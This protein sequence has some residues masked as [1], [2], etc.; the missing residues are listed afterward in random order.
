MFSVTDHTAPAA[1]TIRGPLLRYAIVHAALGS[2]PTD[3]RVT[4]ARVCLENGARGRGPIGCGEC[5][6]TSPTSSE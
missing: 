5:C 2:T 3:A 6:Q 1:G 4:A